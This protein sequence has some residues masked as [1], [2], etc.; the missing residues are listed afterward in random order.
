[1]WTYPL[2]A[3]VGQK[4]VK[5]ALLLAAVAPGGGGVLLRG[6]PG[7]AKSTAA[8]SL[9]GLLPEMEAAADCPFNCPP[10][11]ERRMCPAC[12]ERAAAGTEATVV[13][14]PRPLVTLPLGATE[15]MITG[16]L[17]F[18]AAA[19]SGRRRLTVG[20]LG[21]ANRGVLYVDEINLLDAHLA[22]L[23]LDAAETGQV[24]VEREGVSAIHPARFCLIGSMNPEEGELTPQLLDRFGLV[25]D[26]TAPRDS[27]QRREV[28][29]RRLAFEADPAG[30]C[31]QWAPAQA[32][33]ADRVR[34]ARARWPGVTLP[35]PMAEHIA[36]L[37]ARA[38]AI[39]LRAD[40]TLSRM[41]RA[42]AAWEGRDEVVRADVDLVAGPALVHRR[43]PRPPGPPRV[44]VRSKAPHLPAAGQGGGR[45]AEVNQ[46][47]SDRVN[48]GDLPG[49]SVVE[50]RYLPGAS[51]ELR[52]TGPLDERGSRSRPGRRGS[53]ESARNRGRYVRSSA[54]RLG[55]SV[56]L[57]ATLTAAAPHQV[58][59]KRNCFDPAKTGL[60][61]RPWDIREKVKRERVGRLVI[62]VVD[63]SGSM[64]ALARM[65]EAK[66][67]V[68]ALL[69]DAY[70]NR[71]RVGLVSFRGRRAEVNL[72]PTAS[73]ETAGRRLFDLPTGGRTPLAAGLLCA[74]S[75]ARRETAR[76][77]RL[78]PLL[79][80][81]TDGK[82]NVP[83]GENDPWTEALATARR[84][85]NAP[86]LRWAVVD[87]DQASY[88]DFG[89]AYRLAEELGA[90]YVK[91]DHLRHASLLEIVHFLSAGD[92]GR[93]YGIDS[94]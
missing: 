89:L 38:G 73:V 54:A 22:A 47:P 69:G 77:P 78:T 61:L 1:M 32:G 40:L 63:A 34:A 86:G 31:R 64:G 12:L 51:F 71:D 21:R 11:D 48:S 93:D 13:R 26:L 46:D 67:A 43:R 85:S 18:E 56:A 19:R 58:E 9:A 90:A 83:L 24:R 14:R 62:F 79:I 70:K 41:S 52:L 25:V 80:L 17:D 35:A 23:I 49:E 29:R 3:L 74:L 76:D 36:G 4:R 27:A 65:S 15:D 37:C 45:A 94:A 53:R 20:V 2:A 8:R 39:G 60:I 10:R 30:F 44:M 5:T 33:L 75:L 91:L 57:D 6:E 88:L 42:A 92:P 59:R 82:P 81:L 55:R 72:A 16:T 87:T 7:T 28:I 50:R 68:L 66:A 84:I